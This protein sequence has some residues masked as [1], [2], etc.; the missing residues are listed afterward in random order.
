G[1]VWLSNLEADPGV[2]NNAAAAQPTRVQQLTEKIR[3]WE[4]E[5]KLPPR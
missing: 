2:K 3:A 4:Q 1:K 5:M